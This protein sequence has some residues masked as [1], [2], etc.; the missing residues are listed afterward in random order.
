MIG[1]PTGVCLP[2]R[3]VRPAAAWKRR[4]HVWRRCH[5]VDR[6]WNAQSVVRNPWCVMTELRRRMNDDTQ[7]RGL[8]DRTRETYLWAVTGR[9]VMGAVGHGGAG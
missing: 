4:P 3:L 8:A 2:G 7:V 6:A 1:T 9:R 5:A